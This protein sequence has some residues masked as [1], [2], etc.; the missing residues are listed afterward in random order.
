M[1]KYIEQNMY[2]KYKKKVLKCHKNYK[3]TTEKGGGGTSQ[4]YKVSYLKGIMEGQTFQM[5]LSQNIAKTTPFIA[6]HY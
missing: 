6:C 3:S 4:N 2:R 5:L 1:N